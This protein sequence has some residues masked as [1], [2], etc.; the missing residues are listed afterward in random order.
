[1]H[2]NQFIIEWTQA[3]ARLTPAPESAD[4]S[5]IIYI[6][7]QEFVKFLK[8]IFGDK[9]D[10]SSFDTNFLGKS[11]YIGS[12]LIL[13]F[14]V[15]LII[16][17]FRKNIARL[18]VRRKRSDK[19]DIFGEFQ[20][21]VSMRNFGTA[22]R[23]LIRYITDYTGKKASTFTELFHI[24]KESADIDLADHYGRVMHLHSDADESAVRRTYDQSVQL[25]PELKKEVF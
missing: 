25:I 11:Y 19:T 21:N 3:Q 1:V 10:V 18:F 5:E 20:T 12:I 9:F 23:L 8:K 14:I 15:L 24:K 7:M 17:I 16:F 22:L 2:D 6:A 13:I 4:L